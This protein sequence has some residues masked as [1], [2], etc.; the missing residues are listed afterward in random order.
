M[1]SPFS[2]PVTPDW[3]GLVK[4]V[5]RDGMPDRVHHIELFLDGEM[6][7]EIAR[8]FGVLDGLDASDPYFAEKKQ[9]ALQSFLGYDFIRC[10]ADRF[11]MPLRHEIAADTAG[12]ARDGGRSFVNEHVGPITNWAEFE[13]YPWP[14]PEDVTF[15]S[16]EW[17]EENL[18]DSM[19][20]IG[21]GGFAHFAELLTWLMGYETLCTALFE[22]RDLVQ[23]IADR[24]TAIYRDTVDRML[25]F[26]CVKIVWGSDD[27]GF[28]G[29]PMISP[30][31]MRAFVLPGH[32]LMAEMSHAA[33]RPY[34]LH[35]CGNLALLMDDLIDDVKIDAKHSFE[36]TIEDVREAKHTYGQRI[37]LLGGIDLD[38]LCRRSEA[39]VR[40]RVRDTLEICMGGGGYVLGSGNSIANYVPVENYLAM[41]DE[42]RK[43]RL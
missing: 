9:V 16:L 36:D 11:D 7:D 10:G 14:K 21:S 35:S 19:C 18:P 42:G 28:R 13:A 8:R 30:D 34:L 27:M 29:G 6:Q 17:Y 20:V 43:F 37:A 2:V 3:Q 38:F 25:E 32:K 1:K 22:Q 12:L 39:E 41:L 40:A 15:R 24:L 26:R 4:S 5:L 33:G 23:A 31:D